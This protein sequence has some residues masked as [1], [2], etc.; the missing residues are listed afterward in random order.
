M[1]TGEAACRPRP[2]HLS[3]HTIKTDKKW[4][5]R[6]KNSEKEKSPN[7]ELQW[8]TITDI[9]LMDNLKIWSSRPRIFFRAKAYECISI[10]PL[11]VIFSTKG[12]SLHCIAAGQS[13][14]VNSPA[15]VVPLPLD[16]CHSIMGV[17]TRGE[18]GGDILP[19]TK[20]SVRKS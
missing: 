11:L 19:N 4:K 8:C 20:R 12:V 3:F 17:N 6:R 1:K 5:W 14:E 13:I 10:W 7:F 9:Q 2:L 18:G 16:S 15:W